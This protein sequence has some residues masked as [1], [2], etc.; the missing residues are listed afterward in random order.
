MVNYTDPVGTN[1]MLN[2]VESRPG[3]SNPIYH[4]RVPRVAHGF[5]IITGIFTSPFLPLGADA[6]QVENA[7]PI[8]GTVVEKHQEKEHDEYYLIN[9]MGSS[10]SDLNF[11][12]HCDS[13]DVGVHIGCPSTPQHLILHATGTAPPL[14]GWFRLQFPTNMRSCQNGCT[15]NTDPISIHASATE[16]ENSLE[17]LTLV[18]D[19]S[20]TTTE[21]LFVGGHKVPVTSVGCFPPKPYKFYTSI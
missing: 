2:V 7:I 15:N 3:S 10:L 5:H 11:V 14:E 9:T 18:D 6:S 8:A 13:D 16:V 12:F 19:V 4:F 21:S 17:S 1:A 20:V